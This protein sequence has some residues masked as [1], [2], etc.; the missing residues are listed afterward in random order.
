VGVPGG[1]LR[2]R[3][4][5]LVSALLAVL[6]LGPVLL[7]RGYALTFDMVFVPHLPWSGSLLGLD[8]QPTRAV[9]SDA[10]VSAVS[11]LVTGDIVQKVVLLLIVVGA[12]TGAARLA[13]GGLTRRLGAAVVYVWNPYVYER[14]VLGHWTLLVGYAALPWAV[15]GTAPAAGRRGPAGLDWRVLGPSMVATAAAGPYAATI[16]VPVAVVVALF[17]HEGWPRRLRAAGTVAGTG[18]L[19]AL[20]WTLPVV[21]SSGGLSPDPAGISVFAPRADTALGTVGSLL[22]LGG[23]WNAQVAPPGRD[24]ILVAVVTLAFLALVAV[25]LVTQWSVLGSWR[26]GLLVA[27]AAG[28]V[29][30]L[31][32]VLAAAQLRWLSDEVA[33][34]ALV[35]DS[36]RFVAPWALLCSVGFGCG[37]SWLRARTLGT[38]AVGARLVPV[39]VALLPLALVPAL[40]WGAGGRLVPVAY[41]DGWASAAWEQRDLRQAGAALVLP[42]GAYRRWAWNGQRTV[43]DPAPRY[44]G[45]P[46]YSSTDLP[47]GPVVVRDR[48]G[49]DSSVRTATD[50]RARV[51]AAAALGATVVLTES[52]DGTRV[53]VTSVEPTGPVPSP[54]PAVPVIVGDVVAALTAVVLLGA[55]AWPRRSRV[56]P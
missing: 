20:P 50:D 42:W 11:H 33:A 36:Q 47:V 12:G 30:A 4:P 2:T 46:T 28:V 19:T 6:V 17:S 8:G 37:L 26:R 44:F 23:A 48:S 29:V 35:R 7:R 15:A 9:P 3:L 21:L 14:L 41:P 5:F 27:S 49:P 54:V 31:L 56:L 1:R 53:T 32:P 51:R 18:L 45:G 52:P 43:L 40:V 25:G 16:V 39:V 34:V 10:I 22:G 24:S 38:A 13:G 55:S